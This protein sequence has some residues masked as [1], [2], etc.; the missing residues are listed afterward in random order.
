MWRAVLLSF[1]FLLA[2]SARA[3]PVSPAVQRAAEKVVQGQLD[4][5]AK[6]DAKA[7]F[8]FAAPAL[9]QQLAT[10]ERFMQMLRDGYAILFKPRATR[11]LTAE[12]LGPDNVLLPVRVVGHEGDTVVA[13][14]VLERQADG[15]WR[16]AGCGLE[17]AATE[18]I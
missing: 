3:E 16:I 13:L 6:G 15:S 7:A 17:H 9:Q 2:Q 4:A 18:S 1:V 14:Y 5:L 8:A 10:P 11:L 12:T